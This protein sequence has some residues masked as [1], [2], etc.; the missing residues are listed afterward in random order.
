MGTLMELY[1]TSGSTGEYIVVRTK[2]K[3]VMSDAVV[4]FPADDEAGVLLLAQGVEMMSGGSLNTYDLR[5]WANELIA[6]WQE[7]K[8]SVALEDADG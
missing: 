7:T 8:D 4:F 3:K 2:D 1:R 6:A 5:E